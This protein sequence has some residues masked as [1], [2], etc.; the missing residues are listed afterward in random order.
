MALRR[1]V[2]Q[3]PPHGVGDAVDLRQERLRHHEHPQR[4]VGGTTGWQG[5]GSQGPGQL[6]SRS[7]GDGRV[8]AT[9]LGGPGR[10]GGSQL[11]EPRHASD[12]RERRATARADGV[13]GT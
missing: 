10:R 4:A 11:Q 9:T 3:H 2:L 13:T 12:A 7:Q 5:P 6:G 8:V 1:E